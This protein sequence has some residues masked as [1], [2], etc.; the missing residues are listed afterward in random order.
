MGQENSSPHSLPDDFSEAVFESEIS[1]KY[2]DRLKQAFRISSM[3][4]AGHK[5]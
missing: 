4:R 3:D 5:N 1:T 2:N